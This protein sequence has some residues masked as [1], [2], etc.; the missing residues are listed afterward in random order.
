MTTT[1]GK[2]HAP[3]TAQEDPASQS[4]LFVD[5]TTRISGSS[6][7]DRWYYGIEDKLGQGSVGMAVCVIVA[8]LMLAF[9][10]LVRP[11]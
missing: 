3:P 4:S 1:D 9:A 10:I 7:F 8:A 5:G 2:G 11:I 6:A